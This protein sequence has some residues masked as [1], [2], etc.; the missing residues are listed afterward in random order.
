VSDTNGRNTPGADYNNN[1]GHDLDEITRALAD[2]R[3]RIDALSRE[4]EEITT[5]RVFKNAQSMISD[6]IKVWLGAGFFILVFTGILSY[7]SVVDKAT[8]VFTATILPELKQEVKQ[9]VNTHIYETV[10]RATADIYQVVQIK[11]QQQLQQ[12][13]GQLSQELDKP[14]IAKIETKTV[15]IEEEVGWI[16]LGSFDGERWDTRYLDFAP[17]DKPDSLKGAAHTVR[18]ETGALN[19]RSD[20]PDNFGQ[21][22][23]VIDVLGEGTKVRIREVEQWS[24]SGYWWAYVSY[25]G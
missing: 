6:Y 15:P 9:K 14:D 2:I 21:F 22:A 20:K 11:T 19:V 10:D 12:F 17:K 7:R 18:K 1:P 4:Q 16:Y 25:G 24:S 13:A 3:V 23:K 5:H 8:D